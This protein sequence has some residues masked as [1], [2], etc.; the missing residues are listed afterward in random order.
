MNT[1]TIHLQSAIQYERLDQVQSFVGADDTGS[2]GILAGH[3][4]MLTVLNYGLARYREGT[5]TWV[6]VAVPEAVLHCDNNEVF[7]ST[8]RYFKD[9][10]YERVS[11]VLLNELMAEE[12]EL[13]ATRDS[14]VR[15][16]REMF[17]RLSELARQDG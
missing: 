6:Y 3:A 14:L 7:L 5:S 11:S 12:Q 10:D 2:F 9:A 17:R 8:R 1:F 4:R 13:Q 16:E 15:L